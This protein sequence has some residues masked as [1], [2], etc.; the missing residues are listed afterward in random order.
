MNGQTPS[1]LRR[2]IRPVLRTLEHMLAVVG[3]M[4]LL[5]TFFFQIARMTSS[6]MA[7]AMQGPE[8]GA[9]PDWVLFEK[10]TYRFRQPRRWEIVRTRFRDGSL[11]AKRVVGLPGEEVSIRD[12]RICI[13]GVIQ[14]PPPAL[15]GLKY[16]AAI[17]LR[18]GRSITCRANHV[19]VLGDD[20]RDSWD[21]R[22]EGDLDLNTVEGRALARVWPADRIGLLTP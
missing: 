12:G 19:V 17:L 14:Q 21:S 20:T 18:P 11:V 16:Q 7:P 13:N 10:F 4:F 8:R 2:C 1:R 9:R 5:Y 6:S 15:A 22:F 3:L